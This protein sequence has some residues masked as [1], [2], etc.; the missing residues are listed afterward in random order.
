MTNSRLLVVLAI[1]SLSLFAPCQNPPAQ[2]TQPADELAAAGSQP[3]DP[4][5]LATDLSP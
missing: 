5:P 1:L 2:T 3:D 4:G